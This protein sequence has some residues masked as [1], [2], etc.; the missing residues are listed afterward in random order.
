[1]VSDVI[2]YLK[3]Y[4][5]SLSIV[6]ADIVD[7]STSEVVFNGGAGHAVRDE[8]ITSQSLAIQRS[9]NRESGVEDKSGSVGVISS[10]VTNEI[11]TSVVRKGQFWESVVSILLFDLLLEIVT[12]SSV[13]CSF[14]S[15]IQSRA[16][17]S[18][19]KLVAKFI[20]LKPLASPL[21]S[22]L[23]GPSNRIFTSMLEAI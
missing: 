10:P 23:L 18:S 20:C 9:M 16:Y 2:R 8:I 15:L 22:P 4:N 17:E 3:E 1:M 5:E 19:S 12:Y 11:L 6:S 13:I 7:C 21:P 14:Y